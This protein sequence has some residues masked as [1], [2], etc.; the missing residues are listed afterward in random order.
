MTAL[1]KFDVEALNQEEPVLCERCINWTRKNYCMDCDEF[2]V[3]GHSRG[4]AE[5]S[6]HAYHRTY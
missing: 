2:F 5:L 6:E 4:C 3:A 1:D